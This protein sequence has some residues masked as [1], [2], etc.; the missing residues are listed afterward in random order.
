VI[1]GSGSGTGDGGEGSGG[2]RGGDEPTDSE[3]EPSNY[4]E[5]EDKEEEDMA[6]QNLEWMTQGPLALSGALHMMPKRSEIMLTKYD[7]DN[8][9]KAEDHLDNFYL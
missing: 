8:T 6:D 9:V 1:L 4:E 5:E 3:P 2:G 7:P